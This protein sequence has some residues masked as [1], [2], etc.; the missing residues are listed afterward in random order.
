MNQL[1]VFT[2]SNFA[3]AHLESDGERNI[4]FKEIFT[5]H[6]SQCSFVDFRLSHCVPHCSRDDLIVRKNRH[7]NLSICLIKAAKQWHWVAEYLS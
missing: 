6:S 7:I 1:I 5:L 4:I 3:G 2:S